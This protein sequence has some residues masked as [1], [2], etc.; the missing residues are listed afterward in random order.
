[1][2]TMIN[3]DE[4][5][6][7]ILSK[8]EVRVVEGSAHGDLY[9]LEQTT[10]YLIVDRSTQEVVLAFEGEMSASLSTS[11]GLWDGYRFSG[12]CEVS[13]APDERSALIR[14]HDGREETVPL[15]A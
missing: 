12:V 2:W 10:T 9:D 13:I 3:G 15:P 4:L 6:K 1:M 7:S 5:K 8:F 11:S 14:Y